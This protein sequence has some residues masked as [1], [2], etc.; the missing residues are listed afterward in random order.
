M[1]IQESAEMYLET[2]LVLQNQGPV[3]AVD[4]AKNLGFF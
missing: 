4:I 1:K 2:I 3:R